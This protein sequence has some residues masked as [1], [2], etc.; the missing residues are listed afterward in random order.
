MSANRKLKIL[1]VTSELVPFIKTGGLADVSAALPQV[2]TELGHEVRILVPKYGAIDSRKHKIHDVVRLKDLKIN[3]G[4]KEVIFSLKSSF[5]PTQRVRVQIY[6]LENHEYFG[7][8]K[9]LYSDPLTGELYKD[10][11]ERFILLARSVYELIQKLGWVPDIIHCNDWQTG[12]VPAYL[13]YLYANEPQ[14][15]ALKILFTIHNLHYQGDFSKNIFPKLSLP[16]E[17]NSEKGIVHNGK[18]N[19]LKA[20]LLYS[21]CINTVSETYAKEII[22]DKQISEGL[23]SVLSKRK[24]KVFGVVN[25]ID[26]NVWNPEVD[27]FIPKKFGLKNI[28]N[29]F[30]NKQLLVEKI[31]FKYEENVPLVGMISRLFESKGIDL[32]IDAFDQLMKLNLHFILLGNGEKKYHSIFEKLARKYPNKFS[33]Y[34]GFNDELAHFIEAGSDIFLMPSKYEPCGLNQMYSLVYGTVPVVRRTG[35]LADTV[36][37]YNDKTKEG[38]GF[39]FNKYDSDSLVKEVKKAIQCY[40][41]KKTWFNII[42]NGM[43]TDFSWQSSAKKYIELYKTV[44]SI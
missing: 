7:S 44:L 10:N 27:K 12:L 14:V 26:Y 15:A 33:V 18:I 32:V 8:R 31:G 43:K 1:F 38:N 22:S 37:P 42:K 39:V 41:D 17:L 9:N 34:L 20:G 36:V 40:Q 3:I 2:L 35:G 21:D 19:F 6:F 25:G 23:Y 24:D 4:D 13:K 30:T 29:K 5:L 11:D 16:K 28:I